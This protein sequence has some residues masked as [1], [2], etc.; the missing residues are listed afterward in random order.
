M[1]NPFINMIHSKIQENVQYI[2]DIKMEKENG[3]ASTKWE[4]ELAEL[5]F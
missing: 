1:K 2:T 5:F 4:A 3:T